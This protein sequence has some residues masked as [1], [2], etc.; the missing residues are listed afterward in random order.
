[1]KVMPYVAKAAAATTIAATA[2]FLNTI[3]SQ[4]TPESIIAGPGLVTGSQFFM[5]SKAVGASFALKQADAAISAEL[6]ERVDGMKE[7]LASFK[8]PIYDDLRVEGYQEARRGMWTEAKVAGYLDAAELSTAQIASIRNAGYAGGVALSDRDA[9]RDIASGSLGF[10]PSAPVAA[11]A[12]MLGSLEMGLKHLLEI[13]PIEEGHWSFVNN[14]PSSSPILVAAA[15]MGL[16]S[17]AE[18]IDS[19]EFNDARAAEIAASSEYSLLKPTGWS[20]N[21]KQQDDDTSLSL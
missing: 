3:G 14:D 6:Q 16:T 13:K 19:V 18:P 17:L 7:R 4:A 8:S 2:L 9:M 1:M 15:S 20:P 11:G 21:P 12:A 5:A 10:Q